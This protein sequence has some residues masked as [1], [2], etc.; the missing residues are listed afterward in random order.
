MSNRFAPILS[1][2]ALAVASVACGGVRTPT[3]AGL[4][5]DRPDPDPATY[6]ITDTAVFTIESGLGPMQVTT[7]R[8]G[9]AELDFHRWPDDARVVV[10]FPELRGSFENSTQGA[11]R[12]DESDIGGTFVVRLDHDGRVAVTDTPSLSEALLDI[13][14]PE[15]LVRPLFVHLPGRS[16]ELGDQWVD[17]VTI[18]EESGGT[19]SEV[20][21]VVTSTLAGDTVV[22][23]RRLLRIRTESDGRIEATG[24][25]GGVEIEQRLEGTTVGTV[26]WDD[27]AHQLVERVETGELTGTLVLPDVPTDP[28]AVQAEIRRRV[29]LRGQGDGSRRR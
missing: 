17:T 1:A 10:R 13:T 9:T 16:V 24:V 22:A 6:T 12:V 25:S 8:A 19:R 18:V 23:G 26:L 29:S 5:Y 3:P 28:M 4:S 20:H 7:A 11:S 14:G 15:G 21:S 27:A 2:L